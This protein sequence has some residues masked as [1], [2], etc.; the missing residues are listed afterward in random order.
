MT[1]PHTQEAPLPSADEVFEYF[2]QLSNWGRWGPDDARG[3]LNFVTPGTTRA[4]AAEI[5][6]GRSVSCAWDIVTRQQ[7]GDLFGTPQRYMLNH[8]QA[9]PTPSG[10]CHHTVA[11]TT[12]ALVPASS[13]ASSSTA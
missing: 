9:W 7:E 6:T 3:T 5:V 11:P 8:G 10:S 12:E 2:D 4:A 13:S 1:E